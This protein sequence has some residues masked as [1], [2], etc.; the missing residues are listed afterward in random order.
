MIQAFQKFSQSRVAKVFLAIVALSFVAFFGGG[1]WFRSHDPNAIIAEV[2]N[3][4]IGRPEFAEKVQKQAQMIMAQSGQSLTHEELLQAGVP[5]MVLS[6]LV[7]E[8]L[9]NL[10]SEHLG[11]TVSDEAIRNRI[12]SIKEFHNEKGVFDRTRFTQLLR[13]V[14]FSEDSFI[15]DIRKELIREQLV[16]AI[17]VGTYLP[18]EMIDRLFDA[19]YQHRQASMLVVAPKSMPVPPPPSNDVLEA[20]YKE[21]QTEFKTPELRTMTALVIDP[22][23]MGKEISVS[24][25]EIKSVYEAKPD[26]YGKQ[27]LEKATPQITAEIQ[28]EKANEKVYEISRDLDD[29]IAGGATFEELAP[30][31][32]GAQVVKLE[33][34]DKEGHD[35]MGNTSPALPSNKEF[36]QELLQT[37]FGL[38]EATDNPFTQAKSGTYYTVRVDKVMPEALQPFAEM[39]DRILKIW[40]ENEQL[41]AAYTKAEEYV[42]AFNQGDRKAALMTLLPNLS[43]AEPSSS[44]PDE[45]KALVFSL[46]PNHADMALTSKGFTVVVL[47][48]IIP[49]SQKVKDEKTAP[50]KETLIQHYKEDLLMAYLN[51]LRVRYPVKANKGAMKALFTS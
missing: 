35:R 41:K 14:G 19:Q 48:K 25:D 24:P 10:E 27:P 3:I 22:A 50:F 45:V 38:E 6:Q 49:P 31:V 16:N 28:K 17:I 2:G 15:A 37:A 20:F 5:Q 34:V 9:L 36:A 39:K 46:R 13:A 8:I 33:A 30:T 43:L 42:K 18:E 47:N 44:V 4:S 51:A 32:N 23:T 1:S 12:Q 40:F 7:Q 11:L 29:K 26:V 21:H